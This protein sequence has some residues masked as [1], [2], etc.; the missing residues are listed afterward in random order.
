MSEEV[1]RFPRRV[2]GLRDA[3]AKAEPAPDALLVSHLENARYL[4]GFTGSNAL[5][6]VTPSGAVFLTDGRYDLQAAKEVPGFT[7]VVAPQGTTLQKAA[8]EIIRERGMKNVGFEKAHVTVAQ[9]EALRKAIDG[10]PAEENGPKP[11]A[12]IELTGYTGLVENLRQVKDADE[13]AAL[14]RAIALG[15]ACF[16]H[17]RSFLRPGLTEREVAWEIEAFFRT[18]GAQKLSFDVIAGSG[19]NSAL[20]HGR[21][22][23][24]RIG[25]DG[26]EF[27]LLDFGA[28]LDGYCSDMTRTVVVGGEPTERQREVYDAV[29]AALDGALAMLK[30]GVSGKDVDT[31]AR[32]TLKAR[33]LPEFNHGLGH[34][35]GRVVHDGPAL[36]QLSEVTLAPGMVTTVEPGVYIE[37]FGGVRIE[38]VAVIT[39]SGSEN[40]TRSTKELLVFK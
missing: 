13:V 33:G 20:I 26:P 25:T 19:P 29:R 10:E 18:R 15:D 2:A 38:D 12:G 32:E 21:P 36:S 9:F 7:R 16:E 28:E 3:L 11:G 31:A 4:T 8:A 14:R 27:L 40:L 17:L 37:N 39:E 6:L 5:L 34:S 35:L 30:P 22:S 1:F 23:D 24:R